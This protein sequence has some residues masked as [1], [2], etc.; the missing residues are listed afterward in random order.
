M[1]K[2]TTYNHGNLADEHHSHIYDSQINENDF[3][4]TNNSSQRQFDNVEYY[5]IYV[6]RHIW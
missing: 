1:T 3:K 6:S 4:D 5:F 2:K